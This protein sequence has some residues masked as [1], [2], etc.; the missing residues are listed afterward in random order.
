MHDK[1]Y[2]LLTIYYVVIDDEKESLTMEVRRFLYNR[3]EQR[4]LV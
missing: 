4:R 3:Q 1:K 2:R